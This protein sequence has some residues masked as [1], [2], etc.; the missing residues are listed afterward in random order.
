MGAGAGAAAQLGGAGGLN[1]GMG[2]LREG[3]RQPCN[4]GVNLRVKQLRGKR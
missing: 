2:E 1:V 4:F 3:E